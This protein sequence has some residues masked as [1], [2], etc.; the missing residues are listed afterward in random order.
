MVSGYYLEGE[1]FED[2]AVLSLLAFE[3][4]SP[5]EFQTIAQNFIADAKAAG[6]TKIIVDLQANGGGYIL[7]GYDMFRQFFPDIIQ[8]DYSHI[9]E[10]PTF[11]AIA[12]VLSGAVRIHLII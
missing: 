11:L 7:Q 9:R 5:L 3:N 12:E 6:K 2:V 4:E 10:N 8:E 1:G